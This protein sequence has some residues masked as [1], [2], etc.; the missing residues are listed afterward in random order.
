MKDTTLKRQT[1]TED[2]TQRL[3]A[4][5]F[6][7][8]YLVNGSD[9]VFNYVSF[10]GGAWIHFTP[11]ERTCPENQ[12]CETCNENTNYVEFAQVQCD[13]PPFHFRLRY[14]DLLGQIGQTAEIPCEPT[15]NFG[16]EVF[17]F[18]TNG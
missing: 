3:S 8:L 11:I 12:S 5:A 4:A 9:Y 6:Y 1:I 17:C 13:D 15:C 10:N 18:K 14:K 16:G 7:R 2:K